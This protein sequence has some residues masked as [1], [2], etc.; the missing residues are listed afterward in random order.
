[1][2]IYDNEADRLSMY[3]VGKPC[4]ADIKEAFA[5]AVTKLDI[6]FTPNQEK[7]Y[8]RMLS[9]RFM[10]RAVDGGLVFVNRDSLLRKRIFVMLCLLE[11]SKD[12]TDSFLPQKRNWLHF[13]YIGI[14]TSWAFFT[15]IVG[16]L[17]IKTANVE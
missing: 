5:D 11:A 14:I 8:S 17:I 2:P 15:A 1:M 9:S 16:I 3:L 4:T 7:L 10:M 6:T 12:Y 13:F